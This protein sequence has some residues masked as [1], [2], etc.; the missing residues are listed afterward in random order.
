M[1]I[2][3]TSAKTNDTNSSRVQN[4]KIDAVQTFARRGYILIIEVLIKFF[5]SWGTTESD[6]PQSLILDGSFTAPGC[7]VWRRIS[8][9][10]FLGFS[11]LIIFQKKVLDRFPVNSL[12]NLAENGKDE[13]PI[14]LGR[15]NRGARAKVSP[16][17]RVEEG[18]I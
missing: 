13:T 7:I 11:N 18:L 9:F 8:S 12:F 6:E 16:Y 2:S 14:E 10:P 5:G 4:N 15:K 1:R 3:C 17:D